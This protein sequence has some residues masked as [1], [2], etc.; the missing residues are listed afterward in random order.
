MNEQEV[1]RSAH[2]T[3]AM[4][5]LY[6]A[7]KLASRATPCLPSKAKAEMNNGTTITIKSQSNCQLCQ[8]ATK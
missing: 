3:M 1:K 8:G 6:K 2:M 7:R 4:Q 5:R